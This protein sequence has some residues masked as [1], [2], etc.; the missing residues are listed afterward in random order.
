MNMAKR[1]FL[2]CFMALVACGVFFYV[3]SFAGFLYTSLAGPLHPVNEFALQWML[4][5]IALPV[6]LVIGAV[7]FGLAFRRFGRSE[8]RKIG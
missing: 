3:A 5:H 4:R 1:L 7:I 8:P 2:S 6:S